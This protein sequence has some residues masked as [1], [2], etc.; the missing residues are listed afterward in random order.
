MVFQPQIDVQ[1]TVRF[2]QYRHQDDTPKTYPY[3][4]ECAVTA[5]SSCVCSTTTQPRP[6]HAYALSLS[7]DVATENL[8]VGRVLFMRMHAMVMRHHCLRRLTMP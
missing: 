6:V 3:V 4:V 1:F 2:W 5:S 8:C 7:L